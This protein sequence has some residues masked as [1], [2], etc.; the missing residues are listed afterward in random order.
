MLLRVTILGLWR[1]LRAHKLR[2]LLTIF[3]ITWG[4][5]GV[6]TLLAFGTGIRRHTMEQQHGLGNG[7]VIVWPAKT[8]RPFEGY[9]KGRSLRIN[10]EDIL[11]LPQEI[12]ELE[13]VSPEFMGYVRL[14]V[15]VVTRNSRASGVYPA[16]RELR[17]VFPQPGG[18]FIAQTDIDGR[19]R[20]LFLGNRI[21]E[22]LFG[23]SDPVGQRVLVNQ[24]PFT[25]V[26]WLRPKKQNNTYGTHDANLVFMPATTFATMFGRTYPGLFIY[27]ARHPHQ[28][29]AA[30][31]KVY[32][33]LGRRYQFDPRDREALSLWDTTETN[34][35][36]YYFFLALDLLMGVGGTFTMFV[37]GI[38][39]ANIM[40]IVVRERTPEIGIKMA[41]GARPRHLLAQY[42]L[43]ALLLTAVGGV[44]GFLISWAAM[45]LVGNTG[46]IQYIGRPTISPAV[47]AFTVG[48]LGLVGA[49]AGFFPARRAANMDPVQAL[50]Y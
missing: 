33:A 12:P 34:R 17:H 28:H 10:S 46:A 5:V 9:G 27:R 1:D 36:F 31:R 48:L 11:R 19:R 7:I 23:G 29:E 44:F 38:G 39:V 6:V 24:T 20:V 32:E 50:G 30:T 8:T 45:T 21:K 18:R 16:H 3:G 49:A 13:A 14:R 26:G 37:G 43:E 41:V 22:D 2:A 15:G 35:F 25:V 42:L 4:T 40:Y 47:A